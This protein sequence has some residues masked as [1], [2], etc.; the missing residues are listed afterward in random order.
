MGRRSSGAPLETLDNPQ[1]DLAP[2][3]MSWSMLMKFRV[4]MS[5]CCWMFTGVMMG[6]TKISSLGI[7]ASLAG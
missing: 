1:V 6:S 4:L 2:G 7:P 3:A 5:W